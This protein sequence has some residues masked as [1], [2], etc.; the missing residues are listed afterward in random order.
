MPVNAGICS[1]NVGATSETA[2]QSRQASETRR[3]Y[4]VNIENVSEHTGIEQLSPKIVD[5]AAGKFLFNILYD[6]ST[7]PQT[8]DC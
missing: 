7:R 6:P 5:E 3:N 1:E 4:S 8:A 2:E